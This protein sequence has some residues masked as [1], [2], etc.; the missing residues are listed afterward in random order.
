M[1]RLVEA[2]RPSEKISGAASSGTNKKMNFSKTLFAASRRA[3][4]TTAEAPAAAA[5]SKPPL[6]KKFA[7]YRW[8]IVLSVFFETFLD[9]RSFLES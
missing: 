6:F 1:F 8:V 3:L 4:A 7:V 5:T 2:R 9:T